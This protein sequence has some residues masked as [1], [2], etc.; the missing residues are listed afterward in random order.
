MLI[1]SNL[2]KIED[3]L[4]TF[5]YPSNFFSKLS[6]LFHQFVNKSAKSFSTLVALLF[7]KSIKIIKQTN[8]KPKNRKKNI[9]NSLQKVRKKKHLFL[10]SMRKL[11]FSICQMFINHQNCCTNNEIHR[12][13]SIVHRL[14]V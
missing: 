9:E 12:I 8:E 3:R 11:L 6:K 1:K 7:P 14:L 4:Y 5:F 10:K 2:N 13:E